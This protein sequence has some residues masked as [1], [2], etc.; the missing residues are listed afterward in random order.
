VIIFGEKLT[1]LNTGGFTQGF[2]DK[3]RVLINYD[4]VRIGSHGYGGIYFKDVLTS[5]LERLP[6]RT[7]FPYDFP[8]AKQSCVNRADSPTRYS[9]DEKLTMKKVFK[10]FAHYLQSDMVVIAETGSSMFAT[11]ETMLPHGCMYFGQTFYGSIGYT[12]GACFGASLALKR[13]G[14]GRRVLLVVGDGSFQLTCQE[15]SS[16]V[17]FGCNPL[18]ILVNNDGYLIER[19]IT[20][21]S[22]NDIQMWKYALLP[23]VFG[24]PEEACF[25][26][27]TIEE[28]DKALAY[29][30]S[31]DE[32]MTFVEAIFDKWDCNLLLKSAGRM[33]ALN[34]HLEPSMTEDMLEVAAKEQNS[35]QKQRNELV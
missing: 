10:K 11:A 29:A 5:L 12:V 24:L 2:N 27:Q 16:M 34:N 19:V 33:M 8:R 15:I 25:K 4:N 20:D 9:P 21:N 35:G 31:E 32:H 3:N 13:E 17:R 18:V 14:K 22:Y 7:E 1:D 6:E 28:L 23:Q 30:K 26:C